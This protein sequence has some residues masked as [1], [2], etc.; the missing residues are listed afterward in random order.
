MNSIAELVAAY[1]ADKLKLAALFD[2]VG[3]R[4]TLSESEYQ[5]ERLWLE[6]QRDTAALRGRY[7]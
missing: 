3:A 2:A 5:A 6:Q 7:Q 4:G 1:R